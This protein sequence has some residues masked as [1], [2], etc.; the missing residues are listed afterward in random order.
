MKDPLETPPGTLLADLEKVIN[1]PQAEN[2]EFHNVL[3]ITLFATKDKE[4]QMY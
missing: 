4:K 2:S 3:K 1:C